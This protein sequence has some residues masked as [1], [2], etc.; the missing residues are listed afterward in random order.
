MN[1][2]P[3]TVFLG[4]GSNLGKREQAITRAAEQLARV[5]GTKLMR[6]SPIYESP[7]MLPPDAPEDWNRPFLNAVA[8]YETTLSPELLL[9]SIQRAEKRAGRISRGFWGPRELD[10]DILAYGYIEKYAPHLKLPHPGVPERDFV[11]L[12]WRDIAPDWRYPDEHGPTIAMLC[13]RLKGVTAR[14][15][16]AKAA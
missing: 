11:L 1:T 15:M 2:T 7:A 9:E 14:P 10:V 5:P 6:L 16:L 3:Q 13:D 12:P 4:F 8:H